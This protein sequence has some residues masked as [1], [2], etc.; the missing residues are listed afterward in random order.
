MDFKEHLRKYL[1]EEDIN[2]LIASFKGKE[3]KGLILN[4]NKMS[5]EKLLKLFPNIKKHPIVPN[6]FL[7][8]QDE[9]GMGKTIYHD[10]GC[11][12]I[13]DPSA[14]LVSYFL[15]PKEDEQVLDMCAAPGGKSVQASLLMN[16]K[17]IL[18]SNDLSFKRAEILL[19]NVERMGL[20]NVV[21]LSTDLSEIKGLGNS[22]DKIILDAPCSGSGMFRR[23]EEMKDDWTY[24]KVIKAS[25]IQKDLI[26]LA[27]SFLKE[28]GSLIYSTCSYSYEEDEEV[29][30][31]LLD[32]SDAKLIAL[33]DN[34]MFYHSNMQEAIH[35]FP[36]R[37]IGE[38]HFIALIHKPG[39]LSKNKRE[40]YHLSKKGV[41]KGESKVINH[42]YLPMQ[43]IDRLINIALRP[44]LFTYSEISN[45]KIISHHYSHFLGSENSYCLNDEELKKY[46][47]GESL[48]ILD[49]KN[50]SL[51]SYD[52]N[53]VGVVNKVNNILKNLYPK[54]LRR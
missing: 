53:N 48:S 39:V 3:H 54:G 15:N 8:D 33:P 40:E 45:K 51:V 28:G 20:G 14:S 38:G 16:Q 34:E 23:S 2:S 13:Q 9:Y 44:G 32:N 47:H 31:Y 18:Y 25:H 11:Y 37:Y 4:P 7:Y 50:Y 30:Q 49:N 12:Y 24:E 19:S 42:F 1:S 21:V 41:S 52:G 10:E 43:P 29:V 17:G 26:M 5:E 6:A 22:F 36:N 46:L 27:Y 35:L